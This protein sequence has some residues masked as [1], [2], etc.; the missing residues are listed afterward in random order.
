MNNRSTQEKFNL[1]QGFSNPVAF[2]ANANIMLNP[3]QL[4]TSNGSGQF[5]T[6][7]AALQQRTHNGHVGRSMSI[8]KKKEATKTQSV[9]A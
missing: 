7:S 6:S 3:G 5:I 4:I 9:S 1:I 8:E 2:G